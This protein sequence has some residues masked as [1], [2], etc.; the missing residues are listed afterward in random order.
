MGEE[1]N[2]HIS[3]SHM[4]SSALLIDIKPV[5]S[6]GGV[7]DTDIDQEELERNT[8]SLRDELNEMDSIEKIDLIT[9]EEAPK[10]AKPGGELVEWGSLLV[11]LAA[12]VAP[13]LGNMLQSWVTRHEKHKIV[14]EIGGDKLEV[15]GMS[16]MEQSKLIDAWISN[17]LQN[18][19]K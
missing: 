18:V 12:T 13:S 3:N 1:E 15:T 17:K 8:Q 19:V 14:L 16:D 5:L 9:R 10:G 6:K 7:D 11:T 2:R 4:L